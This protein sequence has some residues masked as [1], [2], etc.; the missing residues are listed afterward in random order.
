M[1][2]TA[3]NTENHK[4]KVFEIAFESH[5]VFLVD[6]ILNKGIPLWMYHIQLVLILISL[7][8]KEM[9]TFNIFSDFR[10]LLALSMRI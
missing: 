1:V 6:V 7:Q 4:N 3:G 9:T 10:P 2:H 8:K 5:C